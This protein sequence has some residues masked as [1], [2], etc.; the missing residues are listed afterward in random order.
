MTGGVLDDKTAAE[1]EADADK[2]VTAAVDFAD[3]SPAPDVATLFDYV[4]ATPVAS[5]YR[6]CPAT[7]WSGPADTGSATRAPRGRQEGRHDG[8]QLPAGAARHAAR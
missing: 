7:A 1:I 2:A 8:D 4:Y 6:G 3:A 5:S